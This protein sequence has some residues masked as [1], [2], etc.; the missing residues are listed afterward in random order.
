MFDVFTGTGR[1]PQNTSTRSPGE[2]YESILAI[3]RLT[4]PLLMS[5]AVAGRTYRGVAFG[6]L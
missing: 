4:A 3:D 1:P 5:E 2:V 6:T